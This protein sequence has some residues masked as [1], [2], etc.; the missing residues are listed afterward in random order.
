[1]SEIPTIFYVSVF[2]LLLLLIMLNL[3]LTLPYIVF[4]LIFF[5]IFLPC[6]MIVVLM[7]GLLHGQNIFDTLMKLVSSV[8]NLEILE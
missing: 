4:L 7:D 1:M 3:I 5:I 8:S 2:K 6:I